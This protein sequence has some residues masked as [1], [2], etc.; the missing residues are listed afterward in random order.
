MSSGTEG[1]NGTLVVAGPDTIQVADFYVKASILH[2]LVIGSIAIIVLFT[3]LRLISNR[4]VAAMNVT[5]WIVNVAIG[6]LPHF[7]STF[8]FFPF[9]GLPSRATQIPRN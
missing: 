5:D 8:S 3:A 6:E 4:S 1:N 7:P 2:P 9:C